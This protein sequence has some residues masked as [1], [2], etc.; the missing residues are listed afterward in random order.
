MDAVL[1]KPLQHKGRLV[2]NM[3]DATKHEHQKN[4]IFALIGVFLDDL[5]FVPAFGSRL[6]DGCIVIY[7][8]G[9][10]FQPVSSTK[11]WHSFRCMGMS[12]WCSASA[13]RRTLGINNKLGFQCI[14]LSFQ[15]ILRGR[16]LYIRDI[17]FSRCIGDTPSISY[18][19]LDG[20]ARMPLG[21]GR[22]WL[23][24]DGDNRIC[25]T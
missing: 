14:N 21:R 1:D 3:S 25:L 17:Q 5:Q 22:A 13:C 18:L 7:S 4:I 12:D 11:R 15:N 10:I 24:I 23:T 2:S 9:M 20:V 8:S 19:R 6:I 16:F